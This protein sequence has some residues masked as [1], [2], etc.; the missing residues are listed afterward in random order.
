M[1]ILSR[2][3]GEAIVIGS[4]VSVTVTNVRSNS[5]SL[6]IEAPED[7]RVDRGEIHVRKEAE[8]GSAC[9]KDLPSRVRGEG[10]SC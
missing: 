4:R 5:V 10:G 9:E 8:S 2:R 6:G 3:I 7:V 1:L